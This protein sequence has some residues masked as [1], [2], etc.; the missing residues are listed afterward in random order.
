MLLRKIES[1]KGFDQF[2][3]FTEHIFIQRDL[4][5]FSTYEL[6]PITNSLVFAQGVAE[7]KGVVLGG[8]DRSRITN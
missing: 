4:L 8:E 3:G 7:A 5:D 2:I 6:L 1:I